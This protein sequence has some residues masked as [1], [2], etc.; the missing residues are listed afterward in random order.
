MNRKFVG[1]SFATPQSY[2]ENESLKNLFVSI[3]FAFEVQSHF[4]AFH[5]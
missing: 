5:P 1:I 2:E 4:F 3:L